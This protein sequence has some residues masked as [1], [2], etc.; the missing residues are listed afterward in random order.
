MITRSDFW[1]FIHPFAGRNFC[2]NIGIYHR[3]CKNHYRRNYGKV[4]SYTSNLEGFCLLF[5]LHCEQRRTKIKQNV[6]NLLKGQ[7]PLSYQNLHLYM[8]EKEYFGFVLDFEIDSF[9]RLGD[10]GDI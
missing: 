5:L 3:I 8:I 9:L 1:F 7:N 4:L 6:T 2:A 10:G